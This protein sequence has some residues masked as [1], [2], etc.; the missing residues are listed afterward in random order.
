MDG[1]APCSLQHS[2]IPVLGVARSSQ[3]ILIWRVETVLANGVSVDCVSAPGA[4]ADSLVVLFHGGGCTMGSAR[5][6][7]HLAEWISSLA[8]C[9]VLVPDY[10]L[11]PEYVYPSQL[12]DARAVY[13]WLLA[14]GQ[15]PGRRE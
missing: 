8:R 1:K 10:R 5:S 2:N 14:R 15:D 6:H 13:G 9:Q 3:D 12:E 4:G 11:V 7:R